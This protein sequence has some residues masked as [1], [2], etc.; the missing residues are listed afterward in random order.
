V[1][2]YW[3]VDPRAGQTPFRAFLL[4]DDAV[5]DELVSSDNGLVDSVVLP[6]FRVD[7][8]WFLRDPLPR[9]SEIIRQIAATLVG[10]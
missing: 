7:P 9:A 2:E 4:N 3:I 1:C 6:G 8:G 5:Y 10:L